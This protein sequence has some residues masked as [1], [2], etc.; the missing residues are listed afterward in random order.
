M[1]HFVSIAALIS[2]SLLTLATAGFSQTTFSDID[3]M[4]GW[5][6][7]SSCAGKFGTGP[8]ASFSMSQNVSSPS[9]DGRSAQFNLG[10]GT[11]YSNVLFQKRLTTSAT[12]ASQ[13]RH[14]I[15]DTYFYYK[16]ATA[17]QGFEFN[18][19][20]YF[21]GKGFLFGIQC[22]IRSSG[23]WE[24][25]APNSSSSTLGSM[26]W[27]STG[28]GCPAP[29]TYKWNHLTLEY[30][31]TSDDKIHYI[32]LTF[33]GSK[34]YLNSYY[35]RRIAPSNWAGITT[36]FQMNGNYRQD[37]YSAWMDKYKVVWW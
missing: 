2:A 1:K 16:N 13:V 22:D 24:L 5:S 14:F 12:T 9:I 25:S 10:G 4:S 29:S 36:H 21:S 23:T 33:N 34:R 37:D 8:T 32:A 15:Y 6:A 35:D 27:V 30:E 7:C 18:I 3:Q 31:R 28:I 17:A 20:E 11:P 19:S 26:H